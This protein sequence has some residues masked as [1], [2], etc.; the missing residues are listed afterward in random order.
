[1]SCSPAASFLAG[2]SLMVAGVICARSSLASLFSAGGSGDWF[3]P[4]AS[5]VFLAGPAIAVSVGL[6]ILGWRARNRHLEKRR[7]SASQHDKA[8][9][10]WHEVMDR[11]NAMYYC[12][13]DDGVFIP[14]EGKFVAID[15][16]HEILYTT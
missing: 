6:V 10:K 15:Q 14:G 5:L 9:A 2:A 4:F 16:M 11:W 12:S 8:V 7:V 13:R 1:M 3:G